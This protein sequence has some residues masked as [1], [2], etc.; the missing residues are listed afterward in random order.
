MGEAGS[1]WRSTLQEGGYAERIL[2][3]FQ[4]LFVPMFRRVHEPLWNNSVYA[5]VRRPY[6]YVDWDQGLAEYY[7][8][9]VLDGEN[10]MHYYRVVVSVY[11]YLDRGTV[12]VEAGRL[13]VP[14][15]SPAGVIDS[16][17]VFLVAP[18]VG[19]L[20]AEMRGRSIRYADRVAVLRYLREKGI[21]EI[22]DM[23]IE[24]AAWRSAVENRRLF[25]RSEWRRIMMRLSKD[26]REELKSIR[27]KARNAEHQR[28]I[29]RGGTI[30]H[31]REHRLFV[32]LHE[33]ADVAF[34]RIVEIICSFWR[35]RVSGLLRR[36]WIQPY[37][38]DYN[39]E[40]IL[41]D[42]WTVSVE[43][44]IEHEGGTSTNNNII[45]GVSQISPILLHILKSLT[46]TF[47][48]FS[49]G[50]KN[51]TD[52]IGQRRILEGAL[53]IFYEHVTL[54]LAS[55]NPEMKRLAAKHLTIIIRRYLYHS[56][57]ADNGLEDPSSSIN[58]S[59][60]LDMIHPIQ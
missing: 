42:Y 35:S 23:E 38:Y 45:R 54:R 57:A 48:W 31:R 49:E 47:I 22:S 52:E 19:G 18:E 16:E 1:L 36:L 56:E 27:W 55:L 15:T 41:R 24:E 13:E 29:I 32:I 37:Q 9:T 51:V 17:S 60:R 20:Y 39:W 2:E 28:W 11:P 33:S 5:Y 46:A 4:G 26:E 3:R 12:K 34:K 58:G 50:L 59:M 30:R 43:G 10:R 14:F 44:R 40:N 25:S 7:V 8:P 53:R 6:Y 21:L